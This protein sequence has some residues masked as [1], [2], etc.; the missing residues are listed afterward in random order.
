M[1]FRLFSDCFPTDSGLFSSDKAPRLPRT[2]KLPA[3]GPFRSREGQKFWEPLPKL[4]TEELECLDRASGPDKL[5]CALRTDTHGHSYLLGRLTFPTARAADGATSSLLRAFAGL[6]TWEPAKASFKKS[7]SGFVAV[8][9]SITGDEAGGTVRI[10]TETSA[11]EEEAMEVARKE[12]V[13]NRSEGVGIWCCGSP[14][15]PD[16]ILERKRNA[17]YHL[18][19][20]DGIAVMYGAHTVDADV[21]DSRYSPTTH[22]VVDSMSVR[23]AIDIDINGMRNFIKSVSRADLGKYELDVSCYDPE[24]LQ[25]MDARDTASLLQHCNERNVDPQILDH[26]Q[27]VVDRHEVG[28]EEEFW[29][30]LG[31]LCRSKRCDVPASCSLLDHER[32]DQPEQIARWVLIQLAADHRRNRRDSDDSDDALPEPGAVLDLSAQAL[33]IPGTNAASS[34]VGSGNNWHCVQSVPTGG[35]GS[36]VGVNA[37]SLGPA[38]AMLVSFWVAK[39]QVRARL[40]ELRLDNNRNICGSTFSREGYAQELETDTSGF[41][42]LLTKLPT[43]KLQKLSFENCCLGKQ[44]MD[45]LQNYL[46]IENLVGPSNSAAD[47]F[48]N[49]EEKRRL[50]DCH[51]EETEL[52]EYCL[53][54]RDHEEPGYREALD[55][56]QVMVKC[57]LKE[58]NLA[59]NEGLVGQ[60]GGNDQLLAADVNQRAFKIFCK[61]M[62]ASLLVSL[63][64]SFCGLGPASLCHLAE[65]AQNPQATLEHLVI[66]GNPLAALP[67]SVTLVVSIAEFAAEQDDDLGFA[68]GDRI[69]VTD[70]S[71]EWWRGY[72]LVHPDVTGMFPSNYVKPDP[73]AKPSVDIWEMKAMVASAVQTLKEAAIAEMSTKKFVD[74]NDERLEAIGGACELYSEGIGQLDTAIGSGAFTGP[75]LKKLEAKR[76]MIHASFSGLELQ[77]QKVEAELAM[78][79]MADATPRTAE[80]LQRV[81]AASGDD[82]LGLDGIK[83]ESDSASEEVT[84]TPPL[85][86]TSLII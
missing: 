41:E 25:R 27:T 32:S 33:S 45:V 26:V 69:V 80:A 73:Y 34:W 59:K 21:S 39:P 2:W 36:L 70:K 79:Q 56:N 20:V 54:K 11:L 42:S 40:V 10:G 55:P 44:A 1:N 53:D 86:L 68:N 74:A 17:R 51:T 49:E 31:R 28:Y 62:G 84:P 15:Q 66:V 23:Q 58:L 64:L 13:V 8:Y 30:E 4:Q 48:H 37:D 65:Y 46:H 29:L 3:I 75:T 81:V 6:A 43:C 72:R 19:G 14:P 83:A 61:R 52:Y 7:G 16:I 5:L 9:D 67:A 82:Q 78:A 76:S 47:A 12:A 38:D 85:R 22:D 57:Q 50:L 18:G 24:L 63:D 60:V 35:S 77:Y 71:Q